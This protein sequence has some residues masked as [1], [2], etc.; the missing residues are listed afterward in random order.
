[1]R[2][3]W[4]GQRWR[5]EG[6]LWFGQKLDMQ[7]MGLNMAPA[8]R[9]I[10]AGP[11]YLHNR[12]WAGLLLSSQKRRRMAKRQL[13]ALIRPYLQRLAQTSPQSQT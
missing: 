5:G 1:M 2:E 13:R 11:A 3:I 9:P 6:G 7:V 12:L 4:A 10:V 8:L